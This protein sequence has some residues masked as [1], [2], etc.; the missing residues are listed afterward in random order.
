MVQQEKRVFLT[1]A[2]GLLGRAVHSTFLADGWIV[3]GVA[4]SRVKEGL[5]KLDL[6]NKEA[7]IKAITEFKPSVV[8]HSAAQRYPDLVEK[9]PDLATVI[10]V[11]ATKYITEAAATVGSRVIYIS[12]DY[13]FDGK[14][15]PYSI[16]DKPNPVNL[17]GKTKLLG[18]E[19]TL[20]VSKSNIVLRVPVLYGPVEKLSESAVTVL[21]EPLLNKSK[22]SKISNYERRRPSHVNDIASICLKLS[23]GIIQ[24]DDLKGIFHWCG[25]EEFTKYDIVIKIAKLFGI[26]HDHIQMDNSSGSSSTSRPY[27]TALDTSRLIKMGYNQHT[28][29]DVGITEVLKPWINK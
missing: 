21:L 20:S 5:H 14:S 12:T 15:A 7:V 4:F 18:E 11:D 8:V 29:F 28:L 24:G 23:T 22:T 9:D 6:T 1:G 13:V 19:V 2:S 26:A 16:T 27:N 17:Y 10:N 3:Y 25:S